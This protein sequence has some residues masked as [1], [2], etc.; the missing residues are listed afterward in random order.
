MKVCFPVTSNNGLDSALYGH[1]ASTPLFLIHDTETGQSSFIPNCDEKNPYGGCNPFS[2][3]KGQQLDGIVVAGIGDESL[4]MMNMCGFKVFQAEIEGLVENV[5]QF[6]KNNLNEI[7]VQNSHLEGRCSDGDG[8]PH[9]CNHSHDHD[10]DQHEQDLC[11]KEQ[12][13]TGNC[14]QAHCS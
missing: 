10:H 12:C 9:T 8:E 14:N 7:F 1:F 3:L 4:R 2:A 13:D 6:E 11:A 5:A